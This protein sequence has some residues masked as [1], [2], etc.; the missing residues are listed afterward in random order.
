[1]L[2]V[3]SIVTT[4]DQTLQRDM[5]PLPELADHLQSQWVLMIQYLGD[6]PAAPDVGFQILAL[7]PR[8]FHAE[9][10]GINR[11]ERSS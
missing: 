3:I 4:L 10:D 8:L 7:E 1:M 9:Q 5:Q 2:L 6:A 11:V